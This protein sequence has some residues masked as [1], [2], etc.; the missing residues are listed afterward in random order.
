MQLECEINL[1][2]AIRRGYDT[3]ATI[4]LEINPAELNQEDR[5]TLANRFKDG[6]Y[7][8][9]YPS[10][11]A[12]LDEPTLEGLL[13]NIRLSSE[14]S[15][16]KTAEQDQKDARDVAE[17]REHFAARSTHALN[18]NVLVYY[19]GSI[20]IANRYNWGSDVSGHAPYVQQ[21]VDAAWKSSA[22]QS[23][24]K[25]L[26][27]TPEGVAWL[28]DLDLENIA[29]KESAIC[30]AQI[31]REKSV[32]FKSANETAKKEMTE[33]SRK[34]AL[35]NGSETL[36]LRIEENLDWEPLFR[37]EWA[38]DVIRRAEIGTPLS[39]KDG[40]TCTTED[41]KEPTAKEIK[42]LRRVRNTLASIPEAIAE[43]KLVKCEYTGKINEEN[44]YKEREV[45]SQNELA[46]TIKGIA[47]EETRYFTAV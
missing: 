34:W 17:A 32:A 1:S 37:E 19:D 16:K 11:T 7:Y 10:F 23:E 26:L 35:A 12:M 28:A 45:I 42:A 22:Y 21:T 43:V 33:I 15:A 31:S 29:A 40:F 24:W 46:V 44:Y 27:A 41:L 5:E 30:M 47:C 25:R 36:R 3:Q 18:L 6:K 13:E 38:D 8:A 2:E 20:S 14:Y 39:D 4:I 9:S